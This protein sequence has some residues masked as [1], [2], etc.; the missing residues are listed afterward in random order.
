MR[1]NDIN[2]KTIKK[3]K[4]RTNKDTIDFA[5]YVWSAGSEVKSIDLIKHTIEYK[6]W[7]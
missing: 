6:G 7:L 1:Q 3:A 2:S 5:K 4:F